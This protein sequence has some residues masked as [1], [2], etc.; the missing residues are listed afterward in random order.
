M[1][2]VLYILLAICLFLLAA[3]W[4]NRGSPKITETLLVVIVVMLSAL[5][6]VA[7]PE[8]I[9]KKIDVLYLQNQKQNE[10]FFPLKG[11]FGVYYHHQY[12]FYP[13]YSKKPETV[14]YKSKLKPYD[15][16]N[17]DRELTDLQ[18]IVLIDYMSM[19]M[20]KFWYTDKQTLFTPP[21]AE[22]AGGGRLG[23]EELLKDVVVYD[24]AALK[25]IGFKDNIFWDTK[26]Q[27]FHFTLPKDTTIKYTTN[28]RKAISAELIFKKI[29]FF[30]IKIQILNRG[31]AMGLGDIG[32]Y[33]GI[34][35]LS[36]ELNGDNPNFR[37]YFHHHVQLRC[38]TDFNRFSSGNPRMAVYKDWTNRLFEELYKQFDWPLCYEGL[39]GRQA[40]LSGVKMLRE[41]GRDGK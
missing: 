32:Y 2:I 16:K 29:P 26:F 11:R 10:L 41:D 6:Y 40:F 4:W 24:D 8:K 15:F 18:A 20:G 25:E 21:F 5:F 30:T 23:D 36:E 14:E 27:E 12:M 33:L 22:E 17:M 28:Y 38:S 3:F 37:D 7:Q 13:A 19:W 34:T 1:K 39:K 35:D 31:G 9:Q